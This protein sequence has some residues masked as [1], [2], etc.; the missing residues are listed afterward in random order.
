M[1]NKELA[2][3]FRSEL[4]NIAISIDKLRTALVNVIASTVNTPRKE[5]IAGIPPRQDA[6]QEGND[7]PGQVALP[8]SANTKPTPPNPTAPDNPWY[9][10]I[11][12]W[13]AVL[14]IVTLVQN[15][16]WHPPFWT[17]EAAQEPDA[18]GLKLRR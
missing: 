1:D 18:G 10:T 5:H 12:G 4:S 7:V 2:K 6:D 8:T 15:S 16:F 3:L 17:G 11:N 14:E 13:K 9:K